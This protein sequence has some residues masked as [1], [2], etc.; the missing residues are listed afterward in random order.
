MML[1]EKIAEY[2]KENEISQ[3]KLAD[4]AGMSENALSLS[5]NGKRK[6]LAD[7]YI[8]ICEAMC[9][10]YSRFTDRPA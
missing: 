2:I 4:R 5:L 7:E 6:L 8:S 9:V 3:K 1:H 10:P